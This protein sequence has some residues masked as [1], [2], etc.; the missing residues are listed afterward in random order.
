M[1]PD[2]TKPDNDRRRFRFSVAFIAQATLTIL[3]VYGLVNAAWLARDI[4]FVAFLAVLFA[5]FLSLGVERLTEYMPRWLATLLTFLAFLGLMTGFFFMVWPS[6]Q[7]QL[8]T[9]REDVP[10]MIQS[11]TD[12]IEEQYLSVMGEME[13]GQEMAA[14]VNQRLG[15]EAASIVAGALPLLNTALGALTGVLVIL[16]AGVFLVAS[17]W[18]Y[19]DGF[20][21]LVPARGRDRLRVAMNEA[22]TS[23]QRWIGGMS[24]SMLVIFLTTTAGLWL[25]GVPAYLALGLIAGLLVFI[26]FVGPILSAVPA[27]AL[28][29]TISPLMGLWVALLFF[30]IQ[31]LESNILT[32]MIMRRAVSLPPAL[33]LLFQMVMS[34]LFGFIGL[35]VAVPLLA[36]LRVFVL[37]LYVD[38]LDD[39]EG[40]DYDPAAAAA[41]SPAR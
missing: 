37:R 39:E 19:R 12:W 22:G 21:S 27:I 2:Y 38:R 5:L 16:F 13:G 10:R 6:L 4:L 7:G 35:L 29:L 8:A 14:T 23:L 25:L 11:I 28:G 9:I 31:Q 30:G 24:L 41:G 32:P 34:V 36:A 18:T 20:L 15:T 1:A 26:P 3:L 40:T 17:P 33:M